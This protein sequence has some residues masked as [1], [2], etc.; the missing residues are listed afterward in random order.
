MARADDTTALG[1][2]AARI[3]EV[4][5]QVYDLFIDLGADDDM[6]DFPV[7]YTI[8]KQGIAKN[9]LDQVSDSLRPLLDT[10]VARIPP[11][12]TS[13]EG[14]SAQMLITN[15]D[16]DNYVGRIGIGRLFGAPL[17]RGENA[18]WHHLTG[19]NNVRPMLIYTWR[20]LKKHEVLEAFP[21]DVVGIAGIPELTVGDTI[22]SGAKREALPRIKVDEPTIGMMFSANTS[23]LAG[24]DGKLL[25]SRQIGERLERE[26]LS[27]VSL[28][29]E[30]GGSKDT[31]KIFGRG[32]L[33]L[34]ILIEQMRREGFELTVSRP[35]VVKKVE[36]GR[37]LEPYEIVTF[38]VPE[39]NVGAITQMLAAR[40]GE[41]RDMR[42]DGS[43]RT[44]VEYR[45]SSRGLIGLRNHV[46]TETRGEGLIL[47]QFDGWDDDAGYIAGRTQGCLVNDRNG[48]TT[49]YALYALQ[50]RGAM[51]VGAGA[52]SYE[53]MIIGLNARG[54]DMNV[55]ACREKALNNIRTTAADEKLILIP[56][57]QLSLEN[58][59]EFIDEDERVEITPTAIRLRK[60]VLDGSKRSVVRGERSTD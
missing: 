47:S 55:N 54:N 9:A 36:N 32:E 29:M 14:D 23:P 59:L 53:G 37:T 16:Y 40:K 3:P 20:G 27:N 38:D 52:D 60:A 41:L 42:T 13:I 31:F 2:L 26:L 6:L 51:F 5:Q 28:R 39:A 24:R 30:E 11:P 19:Q 1:P 34:G 15:L 50:E 49:A 10:I 4:L 43:G 33:Q 8:A 56:P 58:A 48:R 17:K 25:T 12:P 45:I 22:S 18:T 35:E 57:M 44:L 21:G 7:L 46:L